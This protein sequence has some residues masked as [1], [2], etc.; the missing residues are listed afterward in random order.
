[1]QRI[2]TSIIAISLAMIIACFCIAPT[3]VAKADEN[4]PT[5]NVL[6]AYDES[7]EYVFRSYECPV[8]AME[9]RL[10]E[11][12]ELIRLPFLK[13]YGININFTIGAYSDYIGEEYALQCPVDSGLRVLNTDGSIGW[14]NNGQC[15][16][17][18]PTGNCNVPAYAPAHHNNAI[19]LRDTASR[20]AK[21]STNEFNA[22]AVFTA[23]SLC[24]TSG[25]LHTWC[26]GMSSYT[27]NGLVCHAT[28][29]IP[30]STT[31]HRYSYF[32]DNMVNNVI[33]FAHEFSHFAGLRDAD[34]SPN[35]PCIMSGGFDSV[36]SVNNLWCDKCYAQFNM[37]RLYST[38]GE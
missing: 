31:S 25:N 29:D 20:Y 30:G 32:E 24:Y 36:V 1:M 23:M 3:S 34:C 17:Y 18:V 28:Y 22:A 12:T 27:E 38:I 8:S 7:Y 37:S 26:G 9:K 2:T 35:Q 19:N 14:V 16:C 4:S 6:I 33:L 5:I 15:N 11:I 21:Q 13:T 10:Q